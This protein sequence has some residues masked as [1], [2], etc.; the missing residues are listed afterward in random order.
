MKISKFKSE[1][2]QNKSRAKKYVEATDSKGDIAYF[3]VQQYMSR[4]KEHVGAGGRILDMGCGTGV[5]SLALA[6]AGFQVTGVDI[7]NEMLDQ[8]KGKIGSRSIELR[9]GNIFDLPVPDGSFDGIVSRWVLPHFP[10]WPAAVMQAASKLRP[11]GVLFF[12]MCSDRNIRQARTSGV[13]PKSFGYT[14]EA[15]P[16]SKS[17]YA[18]AD[19]RELSLVAA[20]AG[21]ELLSV[22]PLG[23]FRQNAAIASALGEEG[24]AA[25]AQELD[26]HFQA[27]E[28]RKFIQWFESVVTP[29][30]PL[31][32]ATEM[33][34]VMRRPVEG[35]VGA[36]VVEKMKSLLGKGA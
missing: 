35:R 24:Y 19:T 10:Q 6:D 14:F 34:V 15:D 12:D 28:A 30:L 13:I 27:P 36:K 29:G 4:I 11:G 33:L 23:F 3:L 9:V 2:W 7:S 31:A 32:L 5:I 1:A 18:S 25:Y 16:H 26:E 21:L 8:L 17:F 22:Q 20:T